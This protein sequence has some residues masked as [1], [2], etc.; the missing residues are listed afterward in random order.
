MRIP[1]YHSFVCV[2]V[3]GRRVPTDRPRSAKESAMLAHMMARVTPRCA[4][5]LAVPAIAKSNPQMLAHLAPPRREILHIPAAAAVAKVAGLA[6]VKKVTVSKVLGRI[7]PEKAIKD[8]RKLNNHLRERS[9]GLKY[10]SEIADA[11]EQSLD[12]LELSLDAVRGEE[13]VQRLWAW[14]TSLE[15]SNPTL[16]DAVFKSWL[17]VLPGM[18]WASALLKG[19]PKPEREQDG[20]QRLRVSDSAMG[21]SESVSPG[22]IGSDEHVSSALGRLQR[23]H[24]D[25]FATYHVILVPKQD[26][27]DSDGPAR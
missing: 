9:A 16:A 2:C 19:T 11:A 7:G 22:K 13:R 6:A 18:R 17:E 20:S 4:A 8:L 15:K 26:E 1:L 27:I 23:S 3:D 21:A 14:Y 25:I 12:A 24:P 10:S 5:C